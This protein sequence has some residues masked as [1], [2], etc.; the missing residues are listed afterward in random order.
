MLI[1]ISL[2]YIFNIDEII[3]NHLRNFT[4]YLLYN[5]NIESNIMDF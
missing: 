4:Y 2:T 1:E 3:I 5:I